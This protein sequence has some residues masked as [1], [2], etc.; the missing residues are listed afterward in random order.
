[1]P[2]PQPL[3]DRYEKH[4]PR[5]SVT[6]WRERETSLTLAADAGGH[7]YDTVLDQWGGPKRSDDWFHLFHHDIV[8]QTIHLAGA[9]M[10]N[11]QPSALRKTSSGRCELQGAM[12]G[13]TH[14]LHFRPGSPMVP[15]GWNW[16]YKIAV[17][18]SSKEIEVEMKSHSD[19]SLAASLR[20]YLRPNL[21]VREQGDAIH[22]IGAGE[23][24]PLVGGRPVILN[25]EKHRLEIHGLPPASHQAPIMHK[26]PIPSG[27]TRN[28]GCLSLGLLFPV[29]L[30]FRMILD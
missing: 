5:I 27:I 24:I 29:D 6:R 22:Q 3:P 21:T 11:I 8:I 28:C 16:S 7:F 19:V 1:M 15:M 23:T 2:A 13:W 14:T 30:N 9:G 18:R 26:S 25:S 12:P 20:L 4:I 17:T 10:A